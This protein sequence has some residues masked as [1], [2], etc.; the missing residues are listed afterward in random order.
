[1]SQT[2]HSILALS[3]IFVCSS[4]ALRNNPNS[5]SSASGTQENGAPTKVDTKN[6]L[7]QVEMA[8]KRVALR[9]ILR[10]GDYYQARNDA[11]RA[12]EYYETAHWEIK[13]EPNIS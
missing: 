3:I 8:R 13:N 2:I 11:L 6:A 1:M 9:S 7:S 4:C 12:I 10:T 5:G